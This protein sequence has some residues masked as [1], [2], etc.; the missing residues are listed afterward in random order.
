MHTYTHQN[1]QQKEE[2]RL[3]NIEKILNVGKFMK[4][5]FLKNDKLKYYY[6]KNKNWAMGGTKEKVRKE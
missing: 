1:K 4:R 3:P 5:I 2:K 6:I